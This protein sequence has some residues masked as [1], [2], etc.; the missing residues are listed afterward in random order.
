M[1]GLNKDMEE[2]FLLWKL[3][4]EYLRRAIPPGAF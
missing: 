3:F 1:S 2:I 4:L